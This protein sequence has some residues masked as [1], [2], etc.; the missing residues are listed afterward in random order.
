MRDLPHVSGVQ[1]LEADDAPAG[2]ALLQAATTGLC[3]RRLL[4]Q[5]FTLMGRYSL[6]LV[7]GGVGGTLGSV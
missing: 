5:I 3:S 1:E 2:L 6:K 7:R 4:A